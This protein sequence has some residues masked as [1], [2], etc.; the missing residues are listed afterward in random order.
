MH[1]TYQIS[2]ITILLMSL[3]NISYLQIKVIFKRIQA[4]LAIKHT[5]IN[6]LFIN[7]NRQ[8]HIFNQ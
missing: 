2:Q 8:I 7:N 3:L 5:I 6:H 1:L 4:Q